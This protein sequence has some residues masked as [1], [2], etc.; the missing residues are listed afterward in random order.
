MML[1]IVKNVKKVIILINKI[2]NV[3]HKKIYQIVDTILKKL[4]M[5]VF[6]VKICILILLLKMNVYN[7]NK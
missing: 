4:K 3:N 2:N 7:L 5:F 6:N 1:I